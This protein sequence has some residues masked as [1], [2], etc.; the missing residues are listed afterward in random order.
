MN[1]TNEQMEGWTD[2]LTVRNSQH[3]GPSIM[4]KGWVVILLIMYTPFM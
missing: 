3:M 4:K 2:R 1:M